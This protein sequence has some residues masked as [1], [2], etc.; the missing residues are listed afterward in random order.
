M[1]EAHGLLVMTKDWL[2][3]VMERSALDDDDE[4]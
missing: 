4:V 2:R 3:D 1:S